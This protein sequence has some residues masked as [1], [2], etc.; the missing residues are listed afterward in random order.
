MTIVLKLNSS[1]RTCGVS[2]ARQG[3]FLQPFIR[4]PSSPK[5]DRVSSDDMDP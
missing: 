2:T 1:D 3:D 5:S 4:S